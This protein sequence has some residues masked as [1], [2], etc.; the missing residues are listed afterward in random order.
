MELTLLVGHRKV[1]A[2]HCN[3]HGN[4]L[5]TLTSIIFHIHAAYTTHIHCSARGTTGIESLFRKYL[6]IFSSVILDGFEHS[7]QQRLSRSANHNGRLGFLVA[8]LSVVTCNGMSIQ[9]KHL[10]D[11]V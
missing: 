7:W 4:S 5:H 3:R 11:S 2:K 8:L 6:W 9:C 1:S 10:S